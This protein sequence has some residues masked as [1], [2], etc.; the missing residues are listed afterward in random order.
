MTE[1][2]MFFSHHFEVVRRPCFDPSIE[3]SPENCKGLLARYIFSDD[4]ICQV[5]TKNGVCHQKHQHGWLGVTFDG[6]EGLIGRCCAKKYFK[7]DDNFQKETKR[8]DDELARITAIERIKKYTDNKEKTIEWLKD[9]K[10][11]LIDIRKFLED[12]YK[13]IPGGVSK[14]IH[15]A[16]KTRNWSVNVDVGYINIR[17]ENVDG[18]IIEKEHYEWIPSSIG[19]LKRVSLA[20]DVVSIILKIKPIINTFEELLV[21]NI[22]ECTTKVLN[23]YAKTLSGIGDVES[24]TE[25]V[26]VET[27]SFKQSKNLDMLYYACDDEYE[28]LVLTKYI[29][30][31]HNKSTSDGY[32]RL[33]MKRIQ[34]RFEAEFDG[35]MLR[36]NL[37]V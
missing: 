6:K 20:S 16:Q 15:D 23:D 8:I 21:S 17:K 26:S 28:K 36:K 13:S 34:D 25:K 10:N 22:D 35:R 30:S 14:F 3:L 33:R 9:I 19:N 31:L 7:A 11:H 2:S 29:L 37:T 1:K 18:E 4:E 12:M 5:R 27:M 32:V 24:L